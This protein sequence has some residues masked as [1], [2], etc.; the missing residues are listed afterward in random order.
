MKL[1]AT[2]RIIEEVVRHLDKLHI[3]PNHLHRLLS[4]RTVQLIPNP[5][6][7]TIEK[8]R[9]IATDPDDAHV[10]AGAVTSGAKLLLS[11]DKKHILAPNV[12]K[13]LHPMS[14][15][16][17]KGFWWELQKKIK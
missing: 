11:L 10:L 5:S 9:R 2:P 8:F 1:L 17:P 7:E 15:T 6:E 13:A 3:A 16:S 12:G 4:E 14:I